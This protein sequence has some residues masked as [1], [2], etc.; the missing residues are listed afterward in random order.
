MK[1]RSSIS[2]AIEARNLPIIARG[3]GLAS[4][5]LDAG[6]P[7]LI[8]FATSALAPWYDEEISEEQIALHISLRDI[9]PR[10]LLRR[11]NIVDD[12][13]HALKANTSLH[14]LEQAQGRTFR[15]EN[16]ET[17][18][19]KP[20]TA[21]QGVV[22]AAFGMGILDLALAGFIILTLASEEADGVK[23]LD[24]FLP[25][26]ADSISITNNRTRFA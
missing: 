2:R 23:I 26:P 19:L 22:V 25:K 17:M 8:S 7:D 13:D 12:I 24:G 21:A 20:S 14:L 4:G 3:A 10:R 16:C 5:A 11:R 6:A 9:V 1:R 18:L 15:M